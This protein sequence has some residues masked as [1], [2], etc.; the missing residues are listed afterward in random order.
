MYISLGLIRDLILE[1]LHPRV[2][3]H[4]ATRLQLEL[5]LAPAI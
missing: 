2:H 5:Q 4:A 1:S 3:Q